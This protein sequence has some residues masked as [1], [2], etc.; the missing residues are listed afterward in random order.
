MKDQVN[1][2]RKKVSE[3]F[4][5]LNPKSVMNSLRV[6]N[7]AFGAMLRPYSG[8]LSFHTLPGAWWYPR[9]GCTYSSSP[10]LSEFDCVNA[11]TTSQ[12]CM[13]RL[14]SV[15]I[16]HRMRNFVADGVGEKV[17]SFNGLEDC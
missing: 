4:T 5:G 8:F 11:W 6:S 13:G 7:H 10:A 1:S 15:D 16:A 14:S 17:L 3:A 9:G 2:F 12:E